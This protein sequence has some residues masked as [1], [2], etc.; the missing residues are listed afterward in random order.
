MGPRLLRTPK[1]TIQS[2][3]D[4]LKDNTWWSLSNDHL[5][6]GGSSPQ[7]PREYHKTDVKS[8][9]EEALRFR[10]ELP[11]SPPIG[12]SSSKLVYLGDVGSNSRHWNSLQQQCQGARQHCSLSIVTIPFSSAAPNTFEETQRIGRGRTRVLRSDVD[13][14]SIR[15]ATS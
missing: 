5:L 12:N 9:I 15:K 13:F 14:R 7:P 3:S 2:W 10:Q 8:W 4:E 11:G 1:P 6:S